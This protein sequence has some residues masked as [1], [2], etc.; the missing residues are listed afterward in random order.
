M[1]EN[2]IKHRLLYVLKMIENSRKWAVIKNSLFY[3]IKIDYTVHTF[4]HITNNMYILTECH[5][6]STQLREEEI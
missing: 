1:Y 2:D 4:I 3:V 6:I 5:K